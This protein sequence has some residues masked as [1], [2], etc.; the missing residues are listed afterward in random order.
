[1]TKVSTQPPEAKPFE[2]GIE[3]FIALTQAR[4]M[5]VEARQEAVFATPEVLR[6]LIVLSGGQP[7][8]LMILMREAMVSGELPIS[9][10]SVVR[11]KR[12]GKI[13]YL[14]QLRA[15]HWPLIESV[16]NTGALPRD[17]ENDAA[18]R[19]LLDSRAILQYRN[20]A[21]WYAVNP[22]LADTPNPYAGGQK[23]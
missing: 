19:E 20:H 18:I 15:D 8:E 16:R 5:K 12:E 22:F 2:P 1:M 21:E 9:A 3:R 11:A 6:S 14:R 23:A 13:A 4:I 7:R 10:N 17:T